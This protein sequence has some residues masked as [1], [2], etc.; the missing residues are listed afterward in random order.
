MHRT[1]SASAVRLPAPPPNPQ[2]PDAWRDFGARLRHWRRRA[3]LTQAQ[4]GAGIGYDHTAVSKIEHGAR[5]VTPRIAERV[6]E[7]LGAGGDLIA[8]CLRAETAERSKP[9]PF[10]PGLLRPPLPGEVPVGPAVPALAAPAPPRLPDYGLLCPLH[11][12]EGCAVPPPEELAALHAEFCA[13]DPAT[14]APLDDA[15]AHALT[16]L[17]AAHLRAAE[18]GGRP[19]LAA[20]AERTLHAVLARLAA[21]PADQRRP[22][23][24]LAAEHAHAAGAL[25]MQDGRNA[26]AMACFDRA[27]TW[28]ELAGDQATLVG[29][30]SDLSIL[31]RLDGDPV[32][33]LGYA[34][35]IDRVAP[36]RHWAGAMGRISR[37]RALA[38]TGDVRGT[39]RQIGLARTHLDH[40]DDRDEADVP[41]LSIASMRMRVESAA[42]ASLRD[43]SAA[44]DDPRL[45][46]RALAATETALD[47]LGP[48]RLPSSRLLFIVRAADCHACAHDPRTAVE[49]LAPAL[50]CAPAAGL[51]ALVGHELRGLRER[52]APHEP[53]AARRLAELT[54]S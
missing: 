50:E 18:L 23:A 40:M 34:R 13:A 49:L 15:T 3:G 14:A 30:L 2:D 43:L 7:L 32:V 44:V 9:D 46:R 39:L 26:T 20:A 38:L 37:A 21:A 4:L 16:G 25:R 48:T 47:L 28:A 5:R 27:L 8:A 53:Q 6:D 11:G 29:T 22:L 31:A 54:R 1:R 19:G 10:A 33:A 36:G 24:R 41:W 45:A 52:L 35:E 17:L 12:A 42:A 51:P